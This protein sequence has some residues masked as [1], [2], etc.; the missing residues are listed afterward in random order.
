MTAQDG[1]SAA[2]RRRAAEIGVIAVAVILTIAAL[3]V[4][5]AFAVPTVLAA[6]GALALT[7]LARRVESAGAPPGVAA[8]GLVLAALLALAAAVYFVAPSAEALRDD[9]PRLLRDLERTVREFEEEVSEATEVE[10]TA[11]PRAPIEPAYGGGND[12][13]SG[14]EE[15]DAEGDGE[16]VSLVESGRRYITD[17]ALGAPAI[18][19]QAFYGVTL[20]LFLLSEREAMERALVSATQG[21]RA[22]GRFLRRAARAVRIQVSRYLFAITIVNVGLG[23]SVAAAFWA[24]GVPNYAAWGAAMTLLNYMP[25][26]G[27]FIMNVVVFGY[28]VA[29]FPTLEQAL[30]PIAALGVL[31]TIEAYFVTPSVVGSRVR[32]SP[33]SIFF[34]VSFGAW[35][36]GAAGALIAT[37]ALIVL[38]VLHDGWNREALRE[39]AEVAAGRED[40]S[41]VAAEPAR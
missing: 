3:R 19:A 41:P 33:A 26:V 9:A 15:A 40:P 36:W 28:G 8:S 32:L 1:E 29:S 11:P 23:L 16:S 7:P 38:R 17:M 20:M 31:N 6:L 18:I 37:P 27:P 24:L 13:E 25:Y 10:E 35:M 14:G 4:G 2:P 30:Y 22:A 21:D 39:D 12:A 5:E 34:A